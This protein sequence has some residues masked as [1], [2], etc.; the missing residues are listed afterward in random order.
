M[1]LQ[2][3]RARGH[4]HIRGTSPSDKDDH[5][6]S[7]YTVTLW[8]SQPYTPYPP[9]THTPPQTQWSRLGGEKS[10]QGHTE[11]KELK[12]KT[13]QHKAGFVT[14]VCLCSGEKKSFEK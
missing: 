1:S 10:S 2:A 14:P 6:S 12:T 11:R 5:L 13:K 9:N 7:V 3:E 4:M 8:W